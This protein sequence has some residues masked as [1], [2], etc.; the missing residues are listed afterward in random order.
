MKSAVLCAFII[1]AVIFL[2][3]CSDYFIRTNSIWAGDEIERVIGEPRMSMNPGTYTGVGFGYGGSLFAAVTVDDSRILDIEITEHSETIGFAKP[4]F[5]RLIPAIL[6]EQSTSVEVISG[7]TMTSMGLL[8]AVNDALAQAGAVALDIEAPIGGQLVLTPGVFEGVGPGGYGGNIY[9]A[10]TVDENS[11]LDI[12]VLEHGETDMFAMMA[13]SRLIP[14]MLAR[15]TT[16]VDGVSG[17]TY[18]SGALIAAV[19]DAMASAGADIG[20]LRAGPA[21]AGGVFTAGAFVQY[22]GEGQMTITFS[23]ETITEM[24]LNLV[25]ADTDS[26]QTADQI[27]NALARIIT[28]AGGGTPGVS[29]MYETIPGL[30]PVTA[31]NDNDDNDETAGIFTPGV[32]TGRGLGYYGQI[33]LYVT[34]DQNS[35]TDISVIDHSDTALFAD[36]AFAMMIPR[37]LEAQTYEVEMTSG[38]TGTSAG[39]IEAVRNAME[40]AMGAAPPQA[41]EEEDE[42]AESTENND[43]PADGFIPGTFTVTGQGYFGPITLDVT[44]DRDGITDIEVLSHVDTALFADLAFISLIPRIIE[45]QSVD[46]DVVAGATAT[47]AGIIE[48]VQRAMEQAR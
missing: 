46:V 40:Q 20:V 17:A 8:L 41:D 18:T 32:F 7:V 34:F 23:E 3:G 25:N 36:I 44:F 43:G 31:Y 2:T 27:I 6:R 29:L 22:I 47:S 30:L 21:P 19:E 15:Q 11:I 24:T 14:D 26:V 42:D 39:F 10:V 33:S 13:F 12:E 35:I 16:A 1:A 28:E 9:V 4:V 48:A 5:E 38:A 37:V 45:A